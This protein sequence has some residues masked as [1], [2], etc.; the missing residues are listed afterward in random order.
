MAPLPDLNERFVA[1]LSWWNALDHGAKSLDPVNLLNYNGVESWEAYDNGIDGSLQRHP[2][3]QF[4]AKTDGYIITYLDE[5]YADIN[6]EDF[7]SEFSSGTEP[8]LTKTMLSEEIN[9]L[10]QEADNPSKMNFKHSQVGLSNLRYPDM[11]HYRAF[12]TGADQYYAGETEAEYAFNPDSPGPYH[13]IITATASFGGYVTFDGQNV[14]SSGS[15]GGSSNTARL[16][17][18]GA[19]TTPDKYY[20][21]R[22][23]VPL[24]GDAQQTTLI[25]E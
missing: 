14:V 25:V 20:E 3:L 18:Q 16:V 9:A 2:A 8:D 12:Q 15:S 5:T 10:R 23:W 7:L 1:Q 24:A 17:D 21:T 11:N 6:P 13:Y 22:S 19:I 4:R